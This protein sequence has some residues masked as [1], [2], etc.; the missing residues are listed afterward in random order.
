MGY[1]AQE[2]GNGKNTD[3]KEKGNGHLPENISLYYVRHGFI[4]KND[5]QMKKIQTAKNLTTSRSIPISIPIQVLYS[6]CFLTSSQRNIPFTP[7]EVS[8]SEGFMPLV[9]SLLPMCG[10]L[11]GFTEFLIEEGVGK[12]LDVFAL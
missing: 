4:S 10:L 5:S 6:R 2:G 9:L 7:L 11:T 1:L 12:N 3:T 8:L